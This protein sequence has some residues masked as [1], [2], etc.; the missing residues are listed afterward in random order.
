MLIKLNRLNRESYRRIEF[1]MVGGVVM[2]F[3]FV[4]L[5]FLI[6]VCGMNYWFSYV[7]QTI[8]SVELNFIGNYSIAWRDRRGQTNL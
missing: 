3:S 1:L 7:I 2:G 6:S 5:W 8:V 4:Q